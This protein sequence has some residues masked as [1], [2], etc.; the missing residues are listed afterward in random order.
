MV[1]YADDNNFATEVLS[2][3]I[4]VVVDFFTSWCGPCKQ[5]SV[6]LDQLASAY[7][8]RIKVVKENA[9][10]AMNA[11]GEYGVMT[12]PTILMFTNGQAIDELTGAVPMSKLEEFVEKYL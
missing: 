1:V 2:S 3:P 7:E 11:S 4:P 9:E 10:E 6:T 5:L 12:V 8:G